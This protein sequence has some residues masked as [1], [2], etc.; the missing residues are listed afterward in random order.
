MQQMVMGWKA[1]CDE[2]EAIREELLANRRYVGEG[3]SA[4]QVSLEQRKRMLSRGQR[5]M[6][7]EE[8]LGSLAT[9]T[10]SA[11]TDETAGVLHNVGCPKR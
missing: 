10:C 2:W 6:T 4:W 7:Y 9:C 8:I 11:A 3:V 1:E 5:P